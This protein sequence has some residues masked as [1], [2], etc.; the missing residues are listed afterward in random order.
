VGKYQKQ[1][2]EHYHPLIKEHG[3]SF[4]AVDWGSI[5]GQQTRFRI[6]SEVSDLGNASI[7]D[8]GCGIGHFVESLTTA[9]FAGDYKG[10]DL[11]PEMVEAARRRHPDRNFQVAD[12][13][14][15]DG[16]WRADYVFGSGLFT[17][18]DQNLF[19]T[20][21]RAMFAACDRA[22]AFNSLSAWASDKEQGEFQADPLAT[23]R[24]CRTLTPWVSLRHDYFTHD[25]TIY[26]YRDKEV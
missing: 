20:T 19:E 5:K 3:D 10:I 13:S 6:L 18:G 11:L 15:D 26:M 17:F 1:I 24:F 23:L 7:L 25:F 14:A 21:V 2:S 9:G 4:R 8:V 16:N 12:I 22:T